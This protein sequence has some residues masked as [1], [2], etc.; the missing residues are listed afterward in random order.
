MSPLE[1]RKAA[2]PRFSKQL[3]YLNFKTAPCPESQRFSPNRTL[4]TAG[5]GC[6]CRAL[7]RDIGS[8]RQQL[9]T[10]WRVIQELGY[11]DNTRDGQATHLCM[12]SAEILDDHDVGF[13]AID[14]V[15]EQPAPIRG[16]TQS[17]TDLGE[18][19]IQHRNLA[20]LT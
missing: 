3:P 17:R 11:R 19:L 5:I 8:A 9:C 6:S 12:L 16:E 2:M 14:L 15:V 1:S 18:R 13:V 4:R 7:W 10:R 20:A